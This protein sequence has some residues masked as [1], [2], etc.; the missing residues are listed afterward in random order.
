MVVDDDHKTFAA[1][2]SKHL[3]DIRILCDQVSTS[4]VR[5]QQLLSLLVIFAFS[6][7]QVE[8]LGPTSDRLVD[9]DWAQ[10][11]QLAVLVIG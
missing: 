11:D 9:I 2:C 4:E 5:H 6:L 1:Q 10:L 7:A 3:L 8:A